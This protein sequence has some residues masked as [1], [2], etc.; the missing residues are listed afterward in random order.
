MSVKPWSTEHIE[1]LCDT[2]LTTQENTMSTQPEC[3]KCTVDTK[4]EDLC[5]FCLKIHQVQTIKEFLH[6]MN[7]EQQKLFTEFTRTDKG[8]ELILLLSSMPQTTQW[9]EALFNEYQ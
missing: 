3:K 6:S 4:T 8:R 5:N 1:D 2:A 9:Q 7:M